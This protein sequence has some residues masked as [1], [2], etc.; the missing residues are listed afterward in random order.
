MRT[1]GN[2][3]Y[4]Q[5]GEDFT[6]DLRVQNRRGEPYMLARAWRNPYLAITVTAARYEQEGDFRE[7]HWLDLSTR[8]VEQ[9]NG[10]VVAQP[11]KRFTDT[12]AYPLS[13]F[14]IIDAI[15]IYGVGAGGKMVLDPESEN[16]VKNF[17]FFTTSQD[18]TRTFKYLESYSTTGDPANLSDY[19]E[20]WK[21]YSFNV[22]KTFNTNSWTEQKYLYDAKILAGDTVDER[23]INVLTQE[24]TPIVSIGPL[25]PNDWT[26]EIRDY[27][28]TFIKSEAERENITFARKEGLPLVPQY[29]T[30]TIILEPHN[31]FV[32]SNIQGGLR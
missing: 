24:G 12:V 27:L 29:D 4:I 20:I 16:D 13:V 1:V 28:V 10:S 25:D 14:S 31:L 9:Q 21:T 11:I 26:D 6:L 3:V 22:V 7:T 17:L 15:S 8:W 23:I 18:G 32:A 30:K 2:N 5:R 19:T